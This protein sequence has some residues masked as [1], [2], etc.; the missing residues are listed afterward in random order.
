M[1][2]IKSLMTMINETPFNF[3]ALIL[4]YLNIFFFSGSSSIFSRRK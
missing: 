3:M 1:Y 4:R 2:V